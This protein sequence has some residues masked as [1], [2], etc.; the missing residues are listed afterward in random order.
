[1]PLIRLD[2]IIYSVPDI[3]SAHRELTARFPEAW[4]IG[5]FWPD[6]RTSGVAIGGIN[7][8]L[9]QVDENAPAI[10]IATTLAFEP[11]SSEDALFSFRR[12]GLACHEFDKMESDSALLMLRGFSSEDAASAQLICTNVLLDDPSAAPCDFFACSYSP[13]LKQWLAPGNP[14]LYTASHISRILY[15]TPEPEAAA[16]LLSRLGYRGDIEIKFQVNDKRAILG[17]ETDRGPLQWP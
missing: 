14:R 10:P 13:F 4:P 16:L 11:A 9:I 17:I 3:E 6:G 2:H 15:G 1:M 5:R 8:E 12:I 7:L